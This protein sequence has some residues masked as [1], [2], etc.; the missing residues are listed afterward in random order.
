MPFFAVILRINAAAFS[1][2]CSMVKVPLRGRDSNLRPEQSYFSSLA[3][4]TQV[5]AQ[6]S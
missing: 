5:A 3:S 2:I 4:C 1:L 6:A